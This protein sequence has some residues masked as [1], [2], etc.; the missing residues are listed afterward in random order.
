MWSSGLGHQE[1]RGQV[2]KKISIL[3]FKKNTCISFSFAAAN[4]RI[5]VTMQVEVSVRR[6]LF[7]ASYFAP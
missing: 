6:N 1:C 2:A 4:K 7:P 5:T 3:V